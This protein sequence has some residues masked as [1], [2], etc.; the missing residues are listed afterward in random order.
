MC[1]CSSGSASRW[2]GAAS[3]SDRVSEGSATLRAE[4]GRTVCAR[5][6]AD[7]RAMRIPSATLEI[8]VARD[9]L[10]AAECKALCDLIDAE[11]S[12]SQ[13]LSPTTDPEFRTSESCNLN[14]LIP[15][16]A[17][18]S[19]DQ[20]SD[21]HRSAARR[22]HPGPA[23]RGR[24]AVQAASRFLLPGPAL[25]GAMEA[26]GGQR[27]WTA[28]IFLNVPENG[29]QTAFPAAESRSPPRRQPADLEQYG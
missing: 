14:P 21:R 28:M 18:S 7:P 9:F 13:L 6:L 19:E 5:L 12:P 8:F 29:G 11:R 15:W 3:R 27:T 26:S 10:T 4:I 1:G 25:L 23:L 20:R 24:P 16:S 22:D 2:R 17:K